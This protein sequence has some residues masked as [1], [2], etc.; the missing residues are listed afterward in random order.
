MFMNQLKTT[1]PSEDSLRKPSRPNIAVKATAKYGTPF[2][3]VF[4]KICGAKPWS[5]RPTRIRDPEKTF[6]FAALKTTVK[7]TPF[8]MLGSTET[9][10]RFA[11]MTRG[12]L[13]ASVLPFSSCLLS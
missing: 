12:E 10:A 5:A 11:A 6:E 7:M 13:A 2:F 3:D 1:P 4:L 8:M 9:P